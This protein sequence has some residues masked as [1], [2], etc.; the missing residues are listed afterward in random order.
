MATQRTQPNQ[1]RYPSVLIHTANAKIHAV[2]FD[3][4]FNTQLNNTEIICHLLMRY[5]CGFPKTIIAKA[6]AKSALV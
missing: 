4:A 6:L 1:T 3:E 2:Y 5:T